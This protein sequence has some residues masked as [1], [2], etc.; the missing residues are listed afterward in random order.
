MMPWAPPPLPARLVAARQ[1]PLVGRRLELETMEALWSEVT[2]G[3]RQVVFLGGEPG[4]GK[5]RLIAEIAG[6]LH[7]NDVTVLVGTSGLD[8]GVSYQPFAEMLDHLFGRLRRAPW[9]GW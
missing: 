1:A 7:E 4:A 6:A 3:S 2:A 9:P 5:T 8:T